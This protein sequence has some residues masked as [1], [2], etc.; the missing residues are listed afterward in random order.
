MTIVWIIGQN[1]LLGSALRRVLCRAEARIFEQAEC[2][3]WGDETTLFSQLEVAVKSFANSLDEENQWQI[4]WAAGVGTM[5]SAANELAIESRALS[6]LICL[7]ESEGRLIRGLGSFAFASSAGA[8]YARAASYV[9]NENSVVAP[10]TLYAQEKLRQEKMVSRL[11]QSD[12]RVAVLIARI[13]TL[14]GYGQS[15][16]KKQGLIT[17]IAR[18]I[19]RN[20]PIHIYVPLDTIR[21]YIAADDAAAE[22]IAALCAIEGKSSVQ[23][24]IVAAEQPT[25]I[26][27]IVLIFR[28]ISR[29]TP[30]LITSAN[31]LSPIY[32]RRVQFCS[33]NI[34]VK[35][36]I[37]RTSLPVGVAQVLSTERLA[38]VTGG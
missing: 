25:T 28:R 34:P 18:N 33:I 38:F 10:T 13:S 1:G 6:K 35:A 20:Q 23:L 11:V 31:S 17:N 26:A 14:Y 27:E 21:D 15:N 4:Y 24:K 16:R 5:G 8:I 12:R 36:L 37:P 2:F 22:I 9:V 7:I 29:R 30:R 19:V 32:A 3:L